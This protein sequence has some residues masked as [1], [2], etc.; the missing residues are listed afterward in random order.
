M[1]QRKLVV[2]L[3]VM[4]AVAV[5]TFTFAFWA[6]SITGNNNVASQTVV[7]GAGEAVTTTVS[8]NADSQTAG[9]LVPS[10]RAD[11][12]SSATPVE[13]VVIVYTVSLIEDQDNNSYDGQN[14]VLAVSYSNVLIGGVS[15]NA[16]LVQIALS[17]TAT[18]A[19][20]GTQTV[21]ITVTLLEPTQAQYAAIYG[22]DI[23]F[24]LTFT[25]TFA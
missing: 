19:V 14:A 25:A 9:Q 6:A 7:I 23:T 4:L 16:A 13:S 1:K 18:V 8:L 20:D 22:Q 3:L 15:D 24:D 12:S 5:S 17:Y 2:G 10:G 11:N 21:S